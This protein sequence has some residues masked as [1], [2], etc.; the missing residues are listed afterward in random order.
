MREC[1][2]HQACFTAHLDGEL[3]PA[4]RHDLEAHLASCPRCADEW[5]LFTLTLGHFAA[6]RHTPPPP[7]LLP[8]IHA[9]LERPPFWARLRDLAAGL[10][11]SMSLPA[12]AA[13]V[14]VAMAV[15][16]FFKMHLQPLELPGQV[17]QTASRRAP[18]MIIP[19]SRLTT[20]NGHPGPALPQARAAHPPMV[21]ELDD[22]HPDIF[23][24]VQAETPH[25]LPLLQQAMEER[26]L[27]PYAASP[28]VIR[29]R[30]PPDDLP[31]LREALGNRQMVVFPPETVISGYPHHKDSLLVAI[32]LQ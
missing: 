15:G 20:V 21:P 26:H 24:T 11:F 13:T 25:D 1:S 8:G 17:A 30:L 14:A 12:A 5:R 7:D 31:L 32:R 27:A 9:K 22:L 10:D 29:L 18:A 16:F 6:L 2:E 28:H 3:T 4:E 19:D 23:I